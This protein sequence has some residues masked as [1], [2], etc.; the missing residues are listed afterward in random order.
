MKPVALLGAAAL[1]A[2]AILLGGPAVLEA[3][4][5][6]F[7]LW[8]GL[9]IGALAVL[10]I[11]HLLNEAWLQP[12]RPEL[13]AAARTAPLLALLAL[14]V[15]LGLEGLYPWAMPSG[16]RMEGP[17]GVWFSAD[18]FRI[19]SA[20][21]LAILVG[22]GW[23]VARPGT[24]V[25]RSALGLAILL[26]TGSIAAQDWALSRDIEW[27]GSLQGTAMFI[28]QLAAALAG[29]VLLSQLR[30]GH[31][32]QHRVAALERALLT[33]AL[34]TLWLWFVQFVVVWMADL[35]AEAAWYLRRDDGW[36]WLKGGIIL[37]ALV[38]AIVLAIPPR[39]GPV[40]LGTVCGLLLV[41]HIGHLWWLVRPDSP[42]GA[43]ALWLDLVLAPALGAACAA[44]WWNERR[45]ALN[46]PAPATASDP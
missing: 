28:E 1:A 30:Q 39:S 27:F 16:E 20:L 2:A 32:E 45:G 18:A 6:A 17:P 42:V 12:V 5:P 15:L 25:G 44:W 31:P 21:T 36:A 11:G 37:P 29:A 3:W 43:P 34:L 10:M 23:L 35:P 4:L 33:L 38:A 40:R 46:R 41:Q 13:E 9:V 14:P 19:R 24:H 7:M 8:A 22:L 26:P